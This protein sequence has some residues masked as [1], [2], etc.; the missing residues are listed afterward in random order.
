MTGPLPLAGA[1]AALLTPE[2]RRRV[3]WRL[4]DDR[5]PDAAWTA[6]EG[7][8]S[9]SVGERAMVAIAL[10]L[11]N[12]TRAGVDVATLGQLDGANLRRLAGCLAALAEGTPELLTWARREIGADD[13]P[14]E[15]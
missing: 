5:P 6:A 7:G 11:W 14:P 9:L 1:L 4:T 2:L 10:A 8:A 12:G 3:G 15:A 13:Y